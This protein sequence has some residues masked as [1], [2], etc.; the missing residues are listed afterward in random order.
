LWRRD[1]DPDGFF[2]ID[3]SDHDNSVLAFVRR[4]GDAHAIVV[5]NFT[6]VPHEDYRIGAPA[7]GTYVERLSSDAPDYGGSQFATLARVATEP[8]PWHGQGQSLRLRLPPLGALI[9]TPE[10]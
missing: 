3:C 1:P 9:L 5:L 2:W 10:R 7:A 8:H 6:P 4:D